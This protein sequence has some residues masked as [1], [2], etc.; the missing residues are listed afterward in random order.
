MNWG[1]KITLVYIAFIAGILSMVFK[2]RSERVDLVAADYYAQELKYQERMDASSNAN[3]LF[4]FISIHVKN[5]QIQV[6][7]PIQHAGN[8]ED[9]KVHFYCPSD[10]RKDKEVLLNPDENS[11]Q[12]LPMETIAPGNYIAKMQ[13]RSQGKDYFIEKKVKIRG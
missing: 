6:Q 2:A 3:E 4:S 8:I 11:Q 9:A 12:V 5:G 10:A 1:W 13:W 7:L